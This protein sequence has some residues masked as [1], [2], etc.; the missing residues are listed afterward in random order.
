VKTNF[1]EPIDN[2]IFKILLLVARP[3]AGKSE[4][5]HYLSSLDYNVLRKEFHL[6]KMDVLDDFPL[7]WRW[8]EEDDILHQ[9]GFEGIY[10]DKTGY[11][12]EVYYWDLLVRLLNLDYS[13]RLR[14][15]STYHE[16]F[17]TI[18]EFS[19][20]RQHG[21]Y[22]SA[23]SN[24]NRDV[25][26]NLCILYV[27]VTW[28]ESLRK[29]RKRYNPDHPDSI[30]KH[31]IADAKLEKLYRFIDLDELTNDNPEYLILKG[32]QV[33]YVNFQNNDDITTCG[34]VELY[35]WLKSAFDKLWGLY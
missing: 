29:N 7:L 28:E 35:Q 15:S 27:D 30:L 34:G 6:G 24:L 25:L 22:R 9:L 11:F 4:I 18:L 23:F 5:I 20:G 19:R 31:G 13:K 1:Q 8:F 12:H 21:G 17:T 26:Q 14:D 16:D 32:F 33:P 10:T 2:D 3:A